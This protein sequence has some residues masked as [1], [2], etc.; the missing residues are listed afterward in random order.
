VG[1]QEAVEAAEQCRRLGFGGEI[2]LVNPR[3]AGIEPGCYASVAELPEAPDAAFVAVRR[4]TTIEVVRALAERGAGGAVCYAAGF[5]EI[6]GAGVERQAELVAAAGDMPLIGPNC[7]GFLNLLDR[8]ALWPDTHGARPVDEGLA[9]VSQSGNLS[10]TLTFEA[11]SVPLAYVVTAGN[12]AQLG[13]GELMEALLADPRV[14]AIALYIEGLRDVARFSR[15][16]AAAA[17]RGVPVLALKAGRSRKGAALALSHTS[18]LAGTD[19][20]Y[21]ALFARLGVVRVDSPAELLESAKLLMC[22]GP[23]EGEGFASVS[24]SGAEAALIADAA[25]RLGLDFPPFSERQ[26]ER[27]RGELADFVTISNPFDY[28]TSI[29][30]DREA[31]TRCFGNVM[32]GGQALTLFTLD[33]PEPGFA[34]CDTTVDAVIAAARASGGRAALAS[35]LPECLPEDTRDR[36]WAAGVA[37]LQ[38]FDEALAALAAA[39]RYAAFRHERLAPGRAPLA[40]APLRAA[41]GDA[42]NLDEWTAK[43]RLAEHGVAVPEGRLVRAAE[44]SA[45]AAELGFPV[46]VKAVAPSLVHKSELGAVALGLESGEA[47]AAAVAGM[48]ERLASLETEH[49]LVERMVQGAVAELIVGIKRDPL[50]GLALVL[51]AGG[52]WVE[53]LGDRRTLL[54]PTDRAAVEAALAGLASAPLLRG[55]RGRPAGDLAAVV[56]AALAVAEFASGNAARLLELDVNPLLVLERGAVA[57]DVFMRVGGDGKANEGGVQ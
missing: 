37:P 49:V 47:V 46:A 10:L 13:I 12:Q 27:L 38:G 9:I 32:A 48:R 19:E 35:V 11:R 16:A 34:A 43:R 18:S 40:L 14:R 23:L 50:F 51:G 45:A 15:A 8:V 3:R 56:D 2:W 41:I 54:L 42:F 6:G 17:E 33:Y 53:L 20:L 52:V 36:L 30:G 5:A 57:V 22:G 31:L 26:V 4:E 25:E 29:W 28:N 7:Y 44:A 1:G 39:A 24:C 21:E 55:Y